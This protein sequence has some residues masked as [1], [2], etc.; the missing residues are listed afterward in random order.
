MELLFKPNEALAT[1]S[2]EAVRS[3]IAKEVTAAGIVAGVISQDYQAWS[4]MDEPTLDER[5]DFCIQRARHAA[6]AA[7][8][9]ILYDSAASF[10]TT[11][12][13]AIANKSTL[14]GRLEIVSR[15]IGSNV[16]WRA[17]I[18]T[19]FDTLSRIGEIKLTTGCSMHVH[20]SPSAGKTPC[21]PKQMHGILKAI[22]YMDHAITDIVPGSRKENEWAASNFSP[23]KCDPSTGE[24]YNDV[25]Q[26]T[27][28]PLFRE[29]E[30]I[31]ML[32]MISTK[33]LNDKFLSWNFKHLCSSCGTVES[34]RPPGVGDAQRAIYR[35]AVTLGFIQQAICYDW[36]DVK[37]DQEHAD[38][39]FLGE[40][41]V[42]GL[43]R[44]ER[45]C[46]GIIEVMGT[47][48]SQSPPSTWAEK[49]AI[50]VKKKEK[51]LKDGNF[52]AKASH[53]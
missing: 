48:A 49:A 37:C 18:S 16:D 23:G 5:K 53:N 11:A 22:A 28:E 12:P 44:L 51:L 39:G 31:R 46:Q 27:W 47:D 34:R 3:A 7:H 8:A 32:V 1:R 33:V 21:T 50:D 17:E 2:R 42:L 29:F 52:V 26:D 4:I 38:V 30:K 24:L 15:R 35:V 43:S 25:P 9:R 19:V 6:T 41:I 14:T 36:G 20:V 40:F 10:A 13:R 45:T